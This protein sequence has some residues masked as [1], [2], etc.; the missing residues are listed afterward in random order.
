MIKML[1]GPRSDNWSHIFRCSSRSRMC[2]EHLLGP[3]VYVCR[4]FLTG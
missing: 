1:Y 3:S 2:E 4:V